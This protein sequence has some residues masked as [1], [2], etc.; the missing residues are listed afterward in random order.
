MPC[1]YDLG[2]IVFEV[3]MKSWTIRKQIGALSGVSIAFLV[4]V[5]TVSGA[6]VWKLNASFSEFKN[7]TDRTQRLNLIL[8]DLLEAN[9]AATAFEHTADPSFER[10]TLNEIEDILAE[11]T[12][13]DD[14]T[15]A[16]AD[17]AE[18]MTKVIE[19]TARYKSN[20]E[21]LQEIQASKLESI[22][23]LSAAGYTLQEALGALEGRASIDGQTAGLKQITVASQAFVLKRLYLERYIRTQS[24]TDL[25]TAIELRSNAVAAFER[26]AKL[27]GG[28]RFADLTASVQS[29]LDT[30]LEVSEKVLSN[31]SQRNQGASALMFAAGAMSNLVEGAVDAAAAHQVD[32]W[33]KNARN[34]IVLAVVQV[35][36][37]L[38]ALTCLFMSARRIQGYIRTNVTTV[39]SD[40]QT[41]ATGTLDFEVSGVDRDTEFGEMARSLEVFRA[42]AVE[43]KHLHEALRAKEATDE[44]LREQQLEKDQLAEIER[45]SAMEQERSTIIRELSSGLGGV[46]SAAANGD[47]TQRIDRHFGQS[48]LD[49][50]VSSVNALVDGV[51]T[52]I[53]ET[54]RVLSSIADGD[55]TDRM[56]GTHLGLFRDLQIAIDETTATLGGVVHEIAT[57]C[58]AI[59]S[60]SH[61]MERQA[62][63]LSSRAETQAAALEE[64]SAAMKELSTSVQASADSARQSSA[65]ANTAT[66]RV[67][68]A[69][70]VVKESVSAMT[71]IKDASEKIKDIVAVMDSIAYQT[72]LLALNASVEAARAGEAGKGFAVVATEVRALAQRSG[73]A[74]KDIKALIDETVSQVVRGVDLVERTGNTLDEAVEGVRAMS[75]TMDKLTNRAQDQA[76]GVSEVAGA[77]HQMDAITQ[78][79]AA[80][81][82][83]SREAARNLGDKMNVM[84]SMIGR[85]KVSDS[86]HPP[87]ERF[88]AE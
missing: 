60:S 54:A 36:S 74:S 43:A 11:S 45:Q 83:E 78:K 65:I 47:F 6:S 5:A 58:D 56:S 84:Q 53:R 50:M 21:A 42:N 71:D 63:D 32:I 22:E 44:R 25:D 14:V 4:L 13:V 62:D 20:F 85:F 81:A 1:G 41:L 67:N 64:T 39:V 34:A 68:E 80:L 82:D 24:R 72:N 3:T 77:V 8:E 87:A 10:I 18:L 69:G 31:L 26:A 76:A 30:Y 9:T 29:S 73:D 57:Q 49:G 88:A 79:N 59:G 12:I 23:A 7:A 16:S 27:L 33:A 52:S 46:A 37:I 55:L 28:A 51:E 19:Q 61:Q 35:A 66:D 17:F 40:M 75:T 2:Q 38:T 86:D 48:D 70:Q 15:A